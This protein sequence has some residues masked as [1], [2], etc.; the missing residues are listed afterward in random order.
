MNKW[1]NTDIYPKAGRKFLL[2]TSHGKYMCIAKE[3]GIFNFLEPIHYNGPCTVPSILFYK[4]RY[5]TEKEYEERKGFIVEPDQ[6]I[7]V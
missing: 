6:V 2:D 1:N 3:D 4:W 5:I 7:I